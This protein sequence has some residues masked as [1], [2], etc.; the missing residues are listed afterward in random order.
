MDNTNGHVDDNNKQKEEDNKLQSKLTSFNEY[1]SSQD[2]DDN[3]Q[4]EQQQEQQQQIKEELEAG[5]KEVEEKEVSR[6]SEYTYTSLEEVKKT[7]LSESFTTPDHLANHKM[8]E[9]WSKLKSIIS[10]EVFEERKLIDRL[11]DLDLSVE[12]IEKE[13]KLFKKEFVH[14]LFLYLNG[15]N[16]EQVK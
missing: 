9:Y 5:L 7:F 3:I 13:V 12:S 6:E 8:F 11:T 15:K 1:G 10:N 2:D 14:E 16:Q 4:N